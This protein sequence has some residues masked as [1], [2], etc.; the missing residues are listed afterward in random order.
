MVFVATRR[1]GALS[2]FLALGVVAGCS[3]FSMSRDAAIDPGVTPDYETSSIASRDLGRLYPIESGLAAWDG[4]LGAVGMT[5]AHA[6]LP[7]GT[8]TRI[9]NARTGQ[10]AMVQVNRRLD[11]LRGRTVELSR[12]A[13]DAVGALQSGLA[14]VTIE[15]VEHLRRDAGAFASASQATAV[16]LAPPPIASA[17]IETRR[18]EPRPLETRPLETRPIQPLRGPAGAY[19]PNMATG[20]IA[21]HSVPQQETRRAPAIADA[22]F[23]QVG[24]FRDARN[25]H[26]LVDRLD[27]EGMA[28][29]V[30]GGAF[31]ESANVRGEIYHR[32]RIG[33]IANAFEAERA[34]R[35]AKALGHTG[36]QIVRP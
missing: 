9:T 27:A 34:L 8:W 31:V 25:A 32:V 1:A 33:P 28:E 11:P 2:T 10:S 3:E 36:A 13:A 17:P 16:A 4:D 30:Y 26:R 18:L 29:G 20:S 15:P 35:D 22:S 19:D 23:V 5:A 24:S 7:I 12:D 14:T 21:Q 6:D